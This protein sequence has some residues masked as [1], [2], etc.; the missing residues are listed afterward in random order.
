[1]TAD[2][3]LLGRCARVLIRRKARK[4]AGCR[5]FP[6]MDL[7]DLVQE[8]TYQLL[9]ALARYDPARPAGPFVATVVGRAAAQL[10][11][12]RLAAK[13]AAGAPV[14]I[15]SDPG[16]VD[17]PDP[18]A[19]GDADLRIDVAEALAELPDG[20]RAVAELLLTRTVAEAA[21]ERGVPRSSFMRDVERV[22]R[23][24]EDA[25]LRVYVDSPRQSD[26]GVQTTLE[27]PSSPSSEEEP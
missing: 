23:H 13:R 3:I 14:P 1:M 15:G 4:L 9:R 19:A 2:E 18:G 10:V 5:L 16:M 8:L 12:E 24:F 22:R 27:S 20:L 17:P 26:P 21:R 11:R 7:D 25:G 6:E